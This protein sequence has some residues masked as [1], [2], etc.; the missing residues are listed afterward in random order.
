MS[1]LAVIT[2]GGR[3]IGKS[4]A[5]HLAKKG[6]QVVITYRDDAA[7]ANAVAKELGGRAIQLDVTRI[8]SFAAFAA[9]LP[10]TIDVLV[11]NAGTGTYGMLADLTPA[12]FDEMMAVHFKGPLFLTQALLPKLA[13]GASIIQI[14]TGLT[15][16]GFA[17]QLLYASAKAGFEAAIR[18]LALE[19]GARG[20]T[21]NSIAPGGVVTDFG[22]G[23]LR[24]EKLA[25][26]VAG[27]TALGRTAQADD[28]GEIVAALVDMR[29]ATGQ[30]IEAT[31]GYRL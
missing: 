27:E 20:I 28:I 31:G 4:A 24:D 3:G 5:E 30:R 29:W 1:K 12:Q 9:E 16:Y 23:Y 25:A 17:G 13:R 26:I 10:E 7:A 22:G 8:D 15:R 14:S 2:G 6:Y 21:A 19:L 18:Y 11:H